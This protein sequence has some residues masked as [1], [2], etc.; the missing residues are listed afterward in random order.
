MS[1][2]CDCAAVISWRKSG[3]AILLKDK[4]PSVTVWRFVNNRLERSAADKPI[5]K[6][7]ARIKRFRAFTDK[8]YVV[9]HALPKNSRELQEYAKLLEV[10]LLKIVRILS[11]RCVASSVYLSSAVWEN[12]EAMFDT[13]EKQKVI[14]QEIKKIN[15]CNRA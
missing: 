8:L 10:Q 5:V 12:V 9:Y 6:Y 3:V 7:L 11:T 1:V 4:F 13:S 15:E 2:A 14:P